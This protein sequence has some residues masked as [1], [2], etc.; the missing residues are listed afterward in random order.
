MCARERERKSEYQLE[1]MA[2]ITRN[3]ESNGAGKSSSSDEPTA[4]DENTR[5]PPGERRSG[6]SETAR[7]GSDIVLKTH[8]RS[9]TAFSIGQWTYTNLLFLDLRASRVGFSLYI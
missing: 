2:A 7:S 6:R 1:G 9:N 4:K 8:M 3:Q 5:G